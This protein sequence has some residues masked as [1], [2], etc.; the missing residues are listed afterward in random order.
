VTGHRPSNGQ[1]AEKPPPRR[2]ASFF[3]ARKANEFNE[4]KPSAGGFYLETDGDV[5]YG[6]VA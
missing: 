3:L 5:T 4:L 6:F 2:E 1:P